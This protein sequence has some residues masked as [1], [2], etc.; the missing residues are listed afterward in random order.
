MGN[1]LPIEYQANL[2]ANF[3]GQPG[4]F[5]LVYYTPRRTCHATHVS[6]RE[7]MNFE[8]KLRS[9]RGNEQLIYFIP[10]GNKD[11][12]NDVSCKTYGTTY[13]SIDAAIPEVKVVI[14][15]IATAGTTYRLPPAKPK[16]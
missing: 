14:D 8:V 4:D 10:R 12:A 6:S 9:E 13:P 3:V 1:S 15:R 5:V 16:A 11:F 7:K 2:P